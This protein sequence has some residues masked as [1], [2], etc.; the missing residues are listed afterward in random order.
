MVFISRNEWIIIAGVCVLLVQLLLNQRALVRL[1]SWRWVILAMLLIVPPTFLIGTRDT[2]LFGIEFSD[3]GLST[4]LTMAFRGVVVLASIDTV[5]RKI[6]I[7]EISGLLERFGLKGLG[8]SIGVAIN[9]FPSLSRSSRNTWNSIRL[10]GGLRSQHWRTLRL[11]FV[12]I[13]GNALQRAEDIALAAEARAFSPD[14]TSPFPLRKGIYDLHLMVG[15]AV[16]IFGL[17]ITQ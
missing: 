16:S 5:A 15:A 14:R 10:R 13:L 4:G 11:Y 8:F 3:E 17:I 12:T 6:D 2:T 9:F 1:A 7:T